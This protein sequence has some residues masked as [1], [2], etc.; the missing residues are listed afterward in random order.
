LRASC[1]GREPGMDIDLAAL[2]ALERE[3]AL[4]LPAVID[5]VEQALLS[6]YQTATAAYAQARVELDRTSGRITV[7]AREP[8]S[9]DTEAGYGP[10]FD[11]T[12]ED[13]GRFAAD[14]LRQLITQ[15]LRAADDE[16]DRK[17]VV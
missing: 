4:P 2:R 9:T 14:N 8:L 11:H 1:S 13:F 6:A 15:R 3:T 12:P 17:S 5:S 16:R 7:W 10:E